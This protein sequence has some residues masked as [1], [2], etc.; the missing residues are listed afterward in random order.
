MKL[1]KELQEKKKRKSMV[2]K[3]EIEFSKLISKINKKCRFKGCLFPDKT[4]CSSLSGIKAHSIQRNKILTSIS[5]SGKVQCFDARKSIINHDFELVGIG[6]ASTFFGFCS[7]HDSNVFSDIENKDYINSKKQNFFFAYRA[8]AFEYAMCKSVVC[9][10]KE[11]LN[12]AKNE[13]QRKIYSS[14][15]YKDK[16]DLEDI[17][18]KLDRFSGELIKTENDRDYDIIYSKRIQ[19]NGASLL[20]VNSTFSLNY[21]FDGNQIYNPYDYLIELPTIFLNVFPQGNKTNIIFSCFSDHLKKYEKIF[22]QLEKFNISQLENVV[23]Q[24]IVVHCE[25]LFISPNR[26]LK[27]TK[28]KRDLFVSRYEETMVQLPEISYLL[29]PPPL[30]LFKELRD[31]NL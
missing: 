20:A 13:E 3:N 24:I 25:N 5:N 7:Y 14:K 23:S 31:K 15:N 10:T 29:I 16:T 21:D 27:I 26:W 18:K 6:K 22:D 2:S 30:N 19:L 17:K 12:L 1:P 11:L 28:N 8:C 4:L 9:V